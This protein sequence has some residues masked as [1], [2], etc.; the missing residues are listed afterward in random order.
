VR[1]ATGI[2][3]LAGVALAAAGVTAGL[4]LAQ[5]AALPPSASAETSGAP[6]MVPTEQSVSDIRSVQLTVDVEAKKQII[7]PVGGLV[8][9]SRC[10]PGSPFESGTSTMAVSGAPLINFATAVPLWRDLRAGDTGDDVRA[11]QAELSRLGH[12]VA[13][14]GPLTARSVAAYNGRLKEAGGTPADPAVIERASALWIPAPQVVAA[15][16]SANVGATLSDGQTVAEL[17]SAVTRVAAAKVP[18]DLVAGPRVLV[19]DGSRFALTDDLQ[20]ASPD[21]LA[22][23]TATPTYQGIL[24]SGA[25]AASPSAGAGADG[26]GGSGGTGGSAAG[27]PTVLADLELATPVTAWTVAPSS[28]TD[29]ADGS[30]CIV[31]NGT[32]M[33]VTV[34]ASSLGKSYVTFGEGVDAPASIDI[35]PHS[36]TTC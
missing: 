22:A 27:G 35:R 13:T 1:G 30:S 19:I 32:A 8:T 20:L 16:C 3:V 2:T 9:A 4:V 26:D 21:D 33:P 31:S 23:F 11:V 29:I 15:T 10:T 7:T 36:G 25:A 14:K 28:L 34:I 5:P 18:D 24:A 6:T 17:R 12:P